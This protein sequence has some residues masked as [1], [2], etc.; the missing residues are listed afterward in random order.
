MSQR[1]A[2]RGAGSR[3][4][5]WLP[6]FA[7]TLAV[8]VAVWLLPA[9]HTVEH[10][11]IGHWL[12][13]MRGARAAPEQIVLI[14][15]DTAS[16]RALGLPEDFSRWPRGIY[17]RLL[18]E[19]TRAGARAVALNVYFSGARDPGGDA[20]LASAIADAGNV[21]LSSRVAREMRALDADASRVTMD[22]VEPPWP[23]FA[24]AAA[25][26]APFVLPKS[27]QWAD[28]FWSQHPVMD[29]VLSLPAATLLVYAGPA[30]SPWLERLPP[31]LRTAPAGEQLAWLRSHPALWP[32]ASAEDSLEA[33]AIRRLLEEPRV[34]L[35]NFYGP[36]STLQ[37][38]P[39]HE[40]INGTRGEALRGRAVFVGHLE[41][42]YPL[43]LNSFDTPFTQADGLELSGVELAATA[44]G[45]L[46]FNDSMRLAS[47]PLSL[48]LITVFCAVVAASTR[49][50]PVSAAAPA[51]LLLIGAALG[52]ILLA[53]SRLALWLPVLPVLLGG[54]AALLSGTLL[55]LQAT[56]H[57]RAREHH[58]FARY[59][60]RHLVQQITARPDA[61]THSRPA[62]AVILA[63]DA[64]SYTG[65]AEQ[66]DI[67][68][69]A[70]VMN[71]YYERLF[72]PVRESGGI[73]SDVLGDA[74]LALW[75]CDP[76]EDPPRAAACE[77]A[78]A[79]CAAA[80]D[81]RPLATH[82]EL[83]LATR[84][85]LHCGEVLLGSVGAG[86]HFEYRA[87][88][89]TVNTATRLEQLNKRLGTQ[90]LA[91]AAVTAGVPDLPQRPVGAF[92]LP[93][94]NR[95]LEVVELLP[96]AGTCSAPYFEALEHFRTGD[97]TRAGDLFEAVRRSQPDDGVAA[98]YASY[99]RLA[100]R[101]A[102]GVV[103]LEAK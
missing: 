55:H 19:T 75:H 52:G 97:T 38:L 4:R 34:R 56:R 85:G 36:P 96:E 20:A 78:L 44:F 9:A 5:A 35:L 67:A 37:V 45:N 12:F 3:L 70:D 100:G 64:G 1:R 40:V 99:C 16:A 13:Q 59:L 103:T 61:G 74:M 23:E 18:R 86:D 79:I 42:F 24:D 93:G 84:I 102:V 98:F 60:P 31:T 68:T 41:P 58:A 66:Y 28:R 69:V 50:L 82:P 51:T 47:A 33:R 17:A 53:F 2:D 92:L 49:L 63:S 71:R 48:A 57:A 62:A 91:S 87:V 80:C 27:P 73:V 90:I 32:A 101:T 43:Q 77:A 94:K 26:T 54:L 95:P 25:Q 46:L 8:A 72:A 14:A 29:R 7:L 83:R 15:V 21:V 10:D 88:G 76:G 89:D 39:A 22:R 30:L 11:V 65:L 6:V 81:F